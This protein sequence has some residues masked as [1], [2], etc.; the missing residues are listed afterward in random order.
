MVDPNHPGVDRKN[1]VQSDSRSLRSWERNQRYR[2]EFHTS[3][4]GNIHLGVQEMDTAILS[5][6][7]GLIGSL[8]GGVSTFAAAWL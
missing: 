1:S 2:S 7:A 6:S 3:L 5:A 4:H 8:I